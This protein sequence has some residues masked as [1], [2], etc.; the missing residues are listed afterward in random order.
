MCGIIGYQGKFRESDLVVGTKSLAHRGPDDSGVFHDKISRVGLGHTRLSVLDVSILGHQPMMIRDGSLSIVFNGEI[1]NFQELRKS[2][3][4]RGFEFFGKS[5]TEVLLKLYQADGEDMLSSINGIFAFA[6]WDKR[7]KKLFL[8]RDSVGVKPLY[9]FQNHLGFAFSSEI[10][11]LKKIAPVNEGKVDV[12]A[13]HKYMAYLWCPGEGTPLKSVRK[14]EPGHAVIVKD[15]GV[16]KNWQWFSLPMIKKACAKGSQSKMVKSVAEKLRKAVH[17]QM[18]SD[19]PLG[20]FLSGGLDSSSIV[21]FAREKNPEIQCFT[22]ETVNGVESG[23]CDDLPYA[24]KIAK[25]LG[26]HL[27]VVSIDASRMVQDL[28]KMVF[29]LDEP[30]A[31]P[32]ALNVLY[33][34]ELARSQGIKVLLSGTGGDDF[35]SGYRR[36]R[37][38]ISEHWW[39][40]LPQF[41][42][43]GIALGCDNMNQKTL[44]ARRIS[45]I[46]SNADLNREERL[47]EYFRWTKRKDLLPLFSEQVRHEICES[48][49]EKPMMDFL[50]QLPPHLTRLE[51]MLALEQRF[52]LSDH[53]LNYTDKMAMAVGVEVRVP[54]LDIDLIKFIASIP[55]H[56]KQRGK[57]GKWI[58]K[59]AM[60]P[61]LPNDVIYRPKTG[62]GLPLRSWIRNELKDFMCEILSEESLKHRGLFNPNAVQALIQKNEDQKIDASYTI[63]SLICIEL[64]CRHFLDT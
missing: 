57:T 41:F 18:V 5:D 51:K 53:N 22:I 33:I 38:L 23:N 26:V 15:G 42:K 43:K 6:I 56:L 8:A 27:D 37:A 29:Q 62:F 47:L 48:L 10:K 2:L 7:F 34:S 17:R 25:N 20:A 14:L 30:L 31:D 36:H 3:E 35:F 24:K 1:Y 9:Y 44:L 4:R 60:E 45:K 12:E 46:F 54:F 50:D 64:W 32:A 55:S 52:F 19:V 39:D 13:L 21:A 40:W 63:F 28:E 11:A 58:L 59:K 49:A 61:Y 16:I